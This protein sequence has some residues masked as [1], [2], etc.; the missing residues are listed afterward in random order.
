[1]NLRYGKGFRF[2]R[3]TA[4]KLLSA[5]YPVVIK[6]F[7]LPKVLSIDETLDFLIEKRASISRF[8]D[9]ELLY[10]ID[11]I[12]LPFQKQDDRLRNKMIEALNVEVDNLIVGFPIGY[13]SIDNLLPES[14]DTWRSQIA[15]IYPRLRK[16]LP[17]NRTFYNSSMTRPYAHYADK[18]ISK[19]YFE[20]LRRI[21]DDREII[22]I[23]G[24]KSRLGVG[25]DLFAN[26]SSLVRVLAPKHNA[27]SRYD[28]IIDYVKTQDQSKLI[29]IALGP[30]AT[31]MSYDLAK[32]GFQAIDIGN[33]D[34]EYEWY[35]QGATTKVKIKGK[36]TSEAVGGRE[37]DDLDDPVYKSQIVKTFLLDE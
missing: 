12:N 15:W 31:A 23:E 14:K 6:I 5:A 13:Y 19:G 10:I 16:Y 25:N 3:K 20:K 33:V 22:L 34:I 28:D 32:M 30:T 17:K 4:K 24:E 29:L 18:S 1:M 37:V 8:G 9:G 36:Y 21:W 26:A 11:R 27:F 35:L 2:L 7:P